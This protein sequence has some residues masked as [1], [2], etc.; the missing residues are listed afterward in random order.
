MD[1]GRTGHLD[2]YDPRLDPQLSDKSAVGTLDNGS[3]AV[4]KTWADGAFLVG[5]CPK[6]L[7]TGAAQ[8]I[9]V[10]ADKG[11]SVQDKKSPNVDPAGSPTLK[12]LGVHL[13]MAHVPARLSAAW[14]A[15]WQTNML[16]T[17]RCIPRRAKVEGWN[18]NIGPILD[19]GVWR[20]TRSTGARTRIDIDV[21]HIFLAMMPVDRPYGE[22]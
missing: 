19:F 16:L 11:V 18:K 21:T 10:L 8:T 3:P 22:A 13:C 4:S 7:E 14:R 1:G 9:E 6:D 15:L 20:W 12:V 17:T 2:P 5:P